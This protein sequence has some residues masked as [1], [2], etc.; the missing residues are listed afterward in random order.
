M[1]TC[2]GSEKGLARLI[3]STAYAQNHDPPCKQLNEDRKEG[4]ERA[5][6]GPHWQGHP[7]RGDG[8]DREGLNKAHRTDGQT[9]RWVTLG[10]QC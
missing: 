3:K 2:H 8:G 5:Q 1:F 7:G 4:G 10:G 6:L 9:D